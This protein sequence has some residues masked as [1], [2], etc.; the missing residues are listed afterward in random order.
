MEAGEEEEDSDSS[1]I[2]S[3]LAGG[4]RTARGDDQGWLSG[5]REQQPSSSRGAAAAISS[6]AT[7]AWANPPAPRPVGGIG[8]A[9]LSRLQKGDYRSEGEQP[10]TERNGIRRRHH[11]LGDAARQDSFRTNRM[12]KRG[13]R[14]RLRRNLD[15]PAVARRRRI[16]IRVSSYCV[17]RGLETLEL[18]KWLESQPNR[19]LS[20]GYLAEGG[21]PMVGAATRAAVVAAAT[22]AAGAKTGGQEWRGGGEAVDSGGG[23]TGVDV[24]TAGGPTA[25]AAASPGVDGLEWMDSLYI[26]VIHSTTDLRGGLRKARELERPAWEADQYADGE[27]GYG[28]GY[29]EEQEDE[30]DD[31]VTRHKDIMFFPYGAV[32]FWGCSEAEV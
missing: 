2:G 26:D 13:G 12:P 20:I 3:P 4:N 18:L 29:D 28:D 16:K 25:T 21:E 8:G 27:D 1:A 24:E 5:G 22:A 7:W 17:A 6:A 31:A 9:S 10:S 15:R 30:G 19:Q 32:V 23:G 11:P 14:K